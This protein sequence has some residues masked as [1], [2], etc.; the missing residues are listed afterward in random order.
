[1]TAQIADPYDILARFYDLE[2]AEFDADID[3]YRA[4]ATRANGP[5]LE[6]GVGTGRV[7]L[8]LAAERHDVTGIDASE[9]MLS[10]A[11]RRAGEQS[12]A[13]A[14]QQMDMRDFALDRQFD[15]IFCALGSFRHL[16]D[17]EDQ[18]AALTCARRHLS[19]NGL[20]VLHVPAWH[21]LSWDTGPAP[22]LFDWTREDP[23]TGSKVTKFNVLRADPA[24]QLQFLTSIFDVQ[25]SLGFVQRTSIEVPLY[26]FTRSEMEL[27]MERAGLRVTHWYG[28]FE[29]EVYGPDSQEMI[30]VA[31]IEG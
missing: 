15:L 14:L 28:S 5:I 9:A 17:T 8:A 13:V 18:I 6:L 26:T 7:A 1:M 25:D 10:I 31:E 3:L 12:L 4:F 20:L 19:R 11:R 30:A 24:R 22:L 2:T 16:L 29:L 27:L 23:D 21:A